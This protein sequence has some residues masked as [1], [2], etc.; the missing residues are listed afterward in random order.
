M[1]SRDLI[2]G[3]KRRCLASFTPAAPH[4]LLYM[5]MTKRSIRSICTESRLNKS[6]SCV[7][8]TS[9][10]VR[11][12]MLVQ[13][14]HV[15]L[16]RTPLGCGRVVVPR[17]LTSQ[18]RSRLYELECHGNSFQYQSPPRAPKIQRSRKIGL[19]KPRHRCPLC[20]HRLFYDPT[21]QH[22][23]NAR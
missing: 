1:F 10:S 23:P 7:R 15:K 12:G 13:A 14:A 8:V 6:G 19:P 22:V 3:V 11:S 18:D 2:P 4:P 16:C 5:S 20:E 21:L 9:V 17:I